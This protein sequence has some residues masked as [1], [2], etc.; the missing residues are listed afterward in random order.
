MSQINKLMLNMI[1]NYKYAKLL[2]L[3]TIV[4]FYV[5]TYIMTNAYSILCETGTELSVQRKIENVQ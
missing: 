3:I 5:M 2:L 1:V 4:H